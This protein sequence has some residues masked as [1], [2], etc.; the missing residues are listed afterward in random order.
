MRVTV[1]EAGN[2]GRIVNESNQP[3][4]STAA[5]TTRAA[6]LMSAAIEMRAA[7]RRH[8]GSDDEAGGRQPEPEG[9]RAQCETDADHRT[10]EA[11]N[12]DEERELTEASQHEQVVASRV[13][14]DVPRDLGTWRQVHGSPRWRIDHRPRIDGRQARSAGIR[15]GPLRHRCFAQRSSREGHSGTGLHAPIPRK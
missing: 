3:T 10:D 1:V 11:D 12:G 6:R 2:S 9:A 13:D 15:V 8:Q 5:A 14:H 7:A 4:A